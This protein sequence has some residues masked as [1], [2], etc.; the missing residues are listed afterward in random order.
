[1]LSLTRT[2]ATRGATR[3]KLLLPR[4]RSHP[5]PLLPNPA[6]SG[7][8]S[9]RRP[10]A[11]T[12]T[13]RATTNG[14]DERRTT[15]TD[16]DRRRRTTTDD[17]RR[18]TTARGVLGVLERPRGAGRRGLEEAW[19]AERRDA[20]LQ[21]LLQAQ[22]APPL[23]PAAPPDRGRVRQG[24]RDRERPRETASV[25]R[26]VP[27]PL[28]CI[29]GISRRCGRRTTHTNT[30]RRTEHL[31]RDAS[32]FHSATQRE[33]TL[34]PRC[35]ARRFRLRCRR[36]FRPAVGPPVRPAV[37]CVAAAQSGALEDRKSVR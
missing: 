7:A 32:L 16:D 21:D 8:R 22:H 28:R 37:L 5:R 23:P 30:T 31:P 15:T 12:T 6:G 35:L 10:C 20:A 17:D 36:P 24:E 14:N 25:H 4:R 1:M 2:I 9:N 34:S 33:S 19:H 11:R 27:A 18:R 3:Q 26:A 13:M 29:R